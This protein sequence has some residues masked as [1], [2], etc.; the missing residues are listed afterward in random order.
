MKPYRQLPADAGL[1]T[2]AV[3]GGQLPSPYFENAEAIYISPGFLYETAE[4]AEAALNKLSAQKCRR[5]YHEREMHHA[6]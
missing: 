5:G 4:E 2:T 3:H 6:A 1:R